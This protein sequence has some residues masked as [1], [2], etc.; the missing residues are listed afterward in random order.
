MNKRVLIT[1]ITGFLGSHLGRY[2]SNNS[3]SVLAL[4]R[5]SSNILRCQDYIDK[6]EFIDI[7]NEKYISLIIKFKP[8]LIVHC[9]WDGVTSETRNELSIQVKNIE[10]ISI[11]LEIAKQSGSSKFIA[12]GSQAEYG[13]LDQIVNEDEELNPNAS[14]G[15]SKVVSSKLIEKYCNLN[16][17]D[18]YWLRLFSVFG[19]YESDD[20]LISSVIKKIVSDEKEFLFTECDQKYA[21]LYI[22]DFIK[23]VSMLVEKPISAISGIYNVS[24][25][26][27]ITLKSII[28]KIVNIS[29]RND[30]SLKFGAIPKRKNQSTFLEGSMVKYYQNVSS[31]TFTELDNAL[32]KTIDFYKHHYNN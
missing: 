21:Y 30:V 12:I 17:I 6:I 9:A 8:D 27:A 25:K 31:I 2:F 4:K 1:G 29:G 3:Y 14:Y 16:N 13:Y 7:D 11:L 20:W 23:I 19:E 32:E 24:G 10:L 28:E 26:D 22:A 15:I 5:E 18:W